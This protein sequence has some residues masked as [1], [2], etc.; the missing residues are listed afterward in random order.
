[1]AIDLRMF[2]HKLDKY[3]DQLKEAVIDVTRYTGIE[4]N[5]LA[6]IE[7]RQSEPT[8]DEILIRADHYR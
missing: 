2:G 6:S 1:M 8:G 3:R 5:R 4:A 7:A